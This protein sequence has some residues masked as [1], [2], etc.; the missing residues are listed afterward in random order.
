[1][2]ISVPLVCLYGVFRTYFYFEI[3]QHWL[4]ILYFARAQFWQSMCVAFCA[5]SLL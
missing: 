4:K 3:L 1:M 2:K 5:K